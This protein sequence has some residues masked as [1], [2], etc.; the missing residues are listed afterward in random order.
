M[1]I[2]IQNDAASDGA[3]MQFSI[4]C[5]PVPVKPGYYSHP[6]VSDTLLALAQCL[7]C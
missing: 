3:M 1:E 6:I 2:V 5:R 4:Y 7:S